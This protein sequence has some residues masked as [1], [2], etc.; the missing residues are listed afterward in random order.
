M[1]DGA[2]WHHYLTKN[3]NEVG[4]VA[5]YPV[6]NMAVDTMDTMWAGAGIFQNPNQTVLGFGLINFDTNKGELEKIF[7]DYSDIYDKLEK[8]FILDLNNGQDLVH[9]IQQAIIKNEKNIIDNY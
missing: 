3:A 4:T 7:Y 9:E 6:T 8:G 2:S 5:I 1:F